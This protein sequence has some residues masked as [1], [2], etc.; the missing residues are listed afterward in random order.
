MALAEKPGIAS[1]DLLVNIRESN[2]SNGLNNKE[3]ANER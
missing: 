3:L 2:L 1:V